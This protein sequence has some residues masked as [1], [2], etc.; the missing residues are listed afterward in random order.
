M[1]INIY[2]LTIYAV[3]I[4]F[5]IHFFGFAFLFYKVRDTVDGQQ[6]HYE[7]IIGAEI[8]E[9]A[10]FTLWLHG[11]VRALSFPLLSD[12]NLGLF[13]SGGDPRAPCWQYTII[14]IVIMTTMMMII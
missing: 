2:Y 10:G 6:R 13:S 14:T 12:S 5:T 7:Q 3:R 9:G 8:G 11:R 4:T 1:K